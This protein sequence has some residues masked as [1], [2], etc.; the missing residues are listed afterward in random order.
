MDRPEAIRAALERY[1]ED[2][3]ANID[4]PTHATPAPVFD[5]S[6]YEP[7]KPPAL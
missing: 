2:L 4:P 7:N 6:P 1:A 3:L 5:F